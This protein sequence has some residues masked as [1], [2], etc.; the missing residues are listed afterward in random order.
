M[1]GG[2]FRCCFGFFCWRRLSWFRLL[3]WHPRY[4]FGLRRRLSWF[5]RLRWHPCYVFGL[6]AAP[7]LAQA[8]ALASVLCLWFAGGAFPGSGFC[9]GIRAM[10]L[11]CWR[12]LSWFRLLR[13]HPRYVF[14]LLVLPLCGAA[15]TFFAAAKKVSKESG[16][17]PPV[18]VIA[19]GPPSVPTLHAPTRLFAPVASVLAARI[20]RFTLPYHGLRYQMATA[21]QVANCV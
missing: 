8:F 5:G 2:A 15:L 3:R 13:W 14:G 21:A 18:L 7:F 20:T 4:V 17:T 11:V 16:L 1:G 19:C 6:L 12:R 10:S 9:A